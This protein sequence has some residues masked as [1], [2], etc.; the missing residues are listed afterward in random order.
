MR[1]IF[2]FNLLIV[3]AAMIFFSCE[4]D[5]FTEKD[6]MEELQKI[7]V[8]LNIQNGSSHGEPVEGATVKLSAD[9]ANASTV[10]K[11]TDGSGNVVFNDMKIGGNITVYVSKDNYTKASFSVDASTNSYRESRISETLTIYPLDGDNMATVEGQLTIQTDMTN[12]MPE[13][14]ADRQVK[15]VNNS[16]GSNVEQAFVDTTDQEGNYSVQVPVNPGGSDDLR[17]KFPSKIEA[18]QTYAKKVGDTAKVV[19]EPAVYYADDNYDASDIEAVPS[20][21]ASIAAPNGVGSGFELGVEATGTR[22]NDADNEVALIDG[23]G[24]SGYH[25]NNPDVENTVDTTLHMNTEGMYGNST[26]IT[27]TVQKDPAQDSS[28]ITSI[29][30]NNSGAVEYTSKPFSASDIA[31]LVADSLGGSGAMFQVRWETK[32]NVYIENYGSDYKTIPQVS[33]TFREY[34]GNNIEDGIVKRTDE[35]LDDGNELGGININNYINNS[36][37]KLY[38][39]AGNGDTLFVTNGL[40]EMPEVTVSSE[41]GQQAIMTFGTGQIN[42]DSTIADWTLDPHG[43]GYDPANPPEITV[44]SLA[45]YGS[46]AEF[47]VEVNNDGTFNENDIILKDGGEGFVP[48]VNDYQGEDGPSDKSSFN[49]TGAGTDINDVGPGDTE[50]T[51]AYYGTG[52]RMEEE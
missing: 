3:L 50:V 23:K 46:G 9:S 26:E 8:A 40:T 20:A 21:V 19:S 47:Y 36:Q 44:A 42:N 1:N 22:F 18:T 51:E 29:S 24:G 38:P 32:Y 12:R 7:D 4:E 37:G 13:K 45:G 10:E 52:K 43:D 17:V 27:V 6:A 28:S 41:L 5:K 14:L 33:A 25:V 11:T 31:D 30:V 48:N 16:L 34:S 49:V 35:D 2:K 39:D 15:V